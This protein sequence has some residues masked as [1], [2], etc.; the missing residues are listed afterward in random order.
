M[1]KLDAWANYQLGVAYLVR[2]SVQSQD[3]H[4]NSAIWVMTGAAAFFSALYI[5]IVKII[6][7]FIRH[8]PF[9]A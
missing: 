8:R 3:P 2:G 1:D 9:N 6:V 7:Q 5:G 4:T